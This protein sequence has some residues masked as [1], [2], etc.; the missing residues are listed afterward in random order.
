MLNLYLKEGATLTD[1]QKRFI[2]SATDI[3]AENILHTQTQ[4][5]FIQSQKMESIGLLAGGVAHDFNNILTAIKCYAGFIRKDLSPQDPKTADVLEILTATDRAVAL[6]GQLLAFSRRQ[7]LS[8]K[9]TDLNKCVTDT[10]NML[11]RLIGEDIKLTLNL[12]AAPCPAMLDSG[13]VGQVLVNLA[14]NARDAMSG[15]GAIKLSTELLPPTEALFLAHPDLPRG[16]LVC[17]TVADTGC[18]MTAEVK[19]HLF[20]PFFTTKE[21]G[22]GTGLGLATVF[23]IVKQSGGDIAVE[24]EPGKGVLFRICFPYCELAPGAA[25]T[26]SAQAAGG[27]KRGETVL[28][29]EDEDSLLRLGRRVL[30]DGGYTVLT[31]A[32]GPA[33]LKEIERHGKAVDLLVTDLVMPGMSGRELG[34]ELAR[35]NMAGRTLY[36]SGYTDD[37]ILK[38]GVLEQGVAFIYKPFTVEALSVKLREV[39]DGPADKAKA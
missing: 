27:V 4:E 36:M 23:G 8:P 37:A 39:L 30:Q 20:E 9:A 16:P 25:A 5:K 34:R 2:N 15:G 7:V 29:V 19:S 33:A 12:A 6:T 10:A 35:R 11:R 1:N 14:V 21:Q 3:I 18:G 32:S 22:K 31:A 38:H 13:Q 28:L 24:S 26:E 17:L